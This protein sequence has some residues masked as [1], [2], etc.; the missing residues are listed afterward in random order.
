MSDAPEHLDPTTNGHR[1]GVVRLADVVAERVSWL[2]PQHIALGKLCVF[3]GDPNIGKSTMTTDIAARVTTG[4]AMPDGTGGGEPAGVLLLSAEDGLGD[5]V[6]PRAEA[7]GADLSRLHVLEYVPRA[8]PDTGEPAGIRFPSIPAD[9]DHIGRLV[10]ELG[11]RLVIVDV[12][13]AYLHGKVD[14]YRDQDVRGAL[15][16]LSAMAARTS[17]AVVAL[18]HLSKSGGA[19]AIYRGGGSIGIIGA[20]RTGLIVGIDPD[21]PE[22]RILAVTKSNIGRIPPALAYRITEH[23]ELGCGRIEWL[24]PTDHTAGDLVATVTEHDADATDAA[25]VLEEILSDGPVWVKD[26]VD[27]MA[28]AGFS[29]DQAK[30]AK[31]RIRA[32]SVKHGAPG[33]AD[34]GWRWELPE[35]CTKGAKSAGSQDPPPSPPSCTLGTE[36][37]VDR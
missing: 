4:A 37:E 18:R 36:N 14:S 2:W 22:R 3:D 26:A 11:V 32:R 35:G 28:A 34:S 23:A 19:N 27:R 21:D 17:C 29:K 8:D 31:T 24:G 15:M 7:A 12:L 20:A 10:N 9:V 5:T 13:S 25:S 30:R 33:D 16:P 6:R 1:D